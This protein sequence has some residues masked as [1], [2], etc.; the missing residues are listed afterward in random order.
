VAILAVKTCRLCS[1]QYFIPLFSPFKL[2]LTIQNMLLNV[3]NMQILLAKITKTYKFSQVVRI[4]FVI[5]GSAQEKA[6]RKPLV[7]LT[8]GVNITNLYLPSK[9]SPEHSIW[10]KNCH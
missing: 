6:A 4:F 3:V 5:L 9:K 7:N 10:Q 8:P 2:P 1:W